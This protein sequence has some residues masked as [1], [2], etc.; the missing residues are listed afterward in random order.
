MNVTTEDQFVISPA[1]KIFEIWNTNQKQKLL[2]PSGKEN[3]FIN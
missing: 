2:F 1:S 3:F